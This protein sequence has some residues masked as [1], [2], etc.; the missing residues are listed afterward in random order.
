MANEPQEHEEG[1]PFTLPAPMDGSGEEGP[2]NIP[3]DPTPGTPPGPTD[4]PKEDGQQSLENPGPNK[5]QGPPEDNQPSSSH[6]GNNSTPN[7]RNTEHEPSRNSLENT[8]YLPQ[9]PIV[10]MLQTPVPKE[11]PMPMQLV[12]EDSSDSETD[13]LLLTKYPKQYKNPRVDLGENYPP[14]I[15]PPKLP[16]RPKNL[17]QKESATRERGPQII[18]REAAEVEL[19]HDT[20]GQLEHRVKKVEKKLT[21]VICL[22]IGILVL[23][24]LLFVLGFLFLL[25]K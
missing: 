6:S 5:S 23:V 22:L 2:P 16:A 17:G 7:S 10:S 8:P 24:I 12:E 19:Q 4:S 21:C 9:G 3:Q 13:M 14:G 15:P 25:M 20:D 18:L 11:L 1:Q